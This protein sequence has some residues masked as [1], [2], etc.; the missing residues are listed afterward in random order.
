MIKTE[1]L[2]KTMEGTD[3]IILHNHIYV[4]PLLCPLFSR[5][6]MVQTRV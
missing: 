2:I 5:A 1:E 3:L 6:L 4:K